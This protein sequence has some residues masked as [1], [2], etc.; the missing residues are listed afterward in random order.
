MHSMIHPRLRPR[1]AEQAQR[2]RETIE[3]LR[4]MATNVSA[5]SK[6]SV[7]DIT[8]IVHD[9]LAVVPLEDTAKKMPRGTTDEQ[10]RMVL[11]IIGT[12][13]TW[14]TH[15]IGASGVQVSYAADDEQMSLFQSVVQNIKG[16]S[17][18]RKP[19]MVKIPLGYEP[20]ASHKRDVTRA[21]ASIV[22]ANPDDDVISRFVSR[23]YRT[24]SSTLTYAVVA[25][26]WM[27]AVKG[28]LDRIEHVSSDAVFHS[29]VVAAYDLLDVAR[30][31]GIKALHALSAGNLKIDSAKKAAL[32]SIWLAE[33]EIGRILALLKEGNPSYTVA[34][35][36]LRKRMEAE[37]S[38]FN[39]TAI[40]LLSAGQ[41]QRICAASGLRVEP[42]SRSN[43]IEIRSKLR[44]LGLSVDADRLVPEALRAIERGQQDA[45]WAVMQSRLEGDSSWA[46]QLQ[47][48][49]TEAV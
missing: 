41:I 31:D 16:P 20:G 46:D 11:D 33:A 14:L 30:L 47:E 45:F 29:Q 37:P 25:G 5:A 34:V 4:S 17:R 13:G 35:D 8:N 39:P 40:S 19:S 43:E 28:R 21:L 26:V 27:F 36:S 44:T 7:T 9:L 15:S 23:T 3:H 12:F 6:P 18:K 1:I 38:K 32:Q 42:D 48:L 24:R 2:D 10:V 22:A 49:S